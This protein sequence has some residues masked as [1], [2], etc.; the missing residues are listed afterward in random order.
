MDSLFCDGKKFCSIK[1]L[2]RAGRIRPRPDSSLSF[3]KTVKFRCH[4]RPIPRDAYQVKLRGLGVADIK[5]KAVFAV[6][7]YERV[8]VVN[9]E[10][11]P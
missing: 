8:F 10:L 3:P 7:T 9:G 6:G 2:A 11:Q 4:K 1:V 5:I